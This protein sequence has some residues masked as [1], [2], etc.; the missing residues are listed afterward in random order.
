MATSL[1]RILFAGPWWHEDLMQG[2]AR[3]VARRG[4]HLNLE[5]ALSGRLPD[6]WEG[7]GVLTTLG[8]EGDVVERFLER[9]A[10]PGVSLSL[11]RPGLRISR[12]GID[13]RVAGE[14]AASHFLDRGFESFGFY[15]R[16]TQFAGD[17]RREAFAAA[18]QPGPHAVVDLSPG[19]PTTS[20]DWVARQ[21]ELCER[22]TA[23]EKPLAVFAVDDASGVEVIEACQRLGLS[24]PHDVGVL[25]ML[26]MPLFRQSSTVGMSSIRVDFGRLTEV[27]CDVLARL[28]AGEAPLDEPILIAPEGIAARESTDVIAAKHPG[29]AKAIRFMMERYRQPI[30][31]REI[32]QASG[33][34]QARLYV[35]FRQDIGQSPVAVLGR[36]RL[37]K[38]RKQLRET[39]DTIERV[40]AECGFGERINLYRQFKQ[41][42]GMSPGRYRKQARSAGALED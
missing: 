3:H 5:P 41:Q 34:S 6:R 29:V 35:A 4:W 28:M 22:L 20:T 37:D 21:E 18:L 9:V 2:V 40:S 19:D 11:N 12:V 13:N 31:L 39:R 10:C 7:D 36:I 15:D 33:M 1:K 32:V 16:T 8:G 25:G 17:L 38:A 42:L 27:A 23:A 14:M 24:I 30:A 26:D